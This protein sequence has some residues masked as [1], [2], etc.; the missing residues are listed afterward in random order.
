MDCFR[1]NKNRTLLICNN[2]LDFAAYNKTEKNSC[3]WGNCSPRKWLNSTFATLF[4][5]PSDRVRVSGGHLCAKHRST[6]R[7][8]SRDLEPV[9]TSCGYPKVAFALERRQL[10]TAAP[11]RTPFFSHSECSFSKPDPLGVNRPKI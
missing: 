8:G 5:G 1:K 3:N 6:D 4:F 11:F 10:L 9:A 7:G 2:I